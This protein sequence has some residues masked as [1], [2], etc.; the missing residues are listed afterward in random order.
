MLWGYL[1]SLLASIYIV[2]LVVAKV[3]LDFPILLY[4]IHI[5][6]FLFSTSLLPSSNHFP[7]WNSCFPHGKFTSS[8]IL[9]AWKT[10][11]WGANSWPSG[12]V[13]CS[14]GVVDIEVREEGFTNIFTKYYIQIQCQFHL[15]LGNE[16]RVTYITYT[17]VYLWVYN[18][19]IL[20]YMCDIYYIQLHCIEK[21]TY[22]YIYVNK[23]THDIGKTFILAAFFRDTIIYHGML[24]AKALGRRR[25]LRMWPR[26]R[27]YRTCWEEMERQ[28]VGYVDMLSLKQLGLKCK[29]P[30][31]CRCRCR[32]QYY[33]YI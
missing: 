33:I 15:F 1:T 3:R 8:W 31:R 13:P 29:W 28:K 5:H 17:Y 32:Y 30:R 7:C 10:N 21:R 11:L 4:H 20:S 14:L 9:D 12:M 25:I 6:L 19:Y 26:L 24:L 27:R 23:Y 2:V 18:V 22:I 16:S